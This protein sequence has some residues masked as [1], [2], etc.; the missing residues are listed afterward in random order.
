MDEQQRIIVV[1]AKIQSFFEESHEP[2]HVLERRYNHISTLQAMILSSSSKGIALF[3][4]TFEKKN[5]VC[6]VSANEDYFPDTYEDRI[7][8]IRNVKGGGAPAISYNNDA[9]ISY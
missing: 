7:T 3:S 4:S 1:V 5:E 8:A 6:S 9:F 2:F